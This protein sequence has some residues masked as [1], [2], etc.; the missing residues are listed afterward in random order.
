M[1]RPLVSV[2]VP[3]YN[4]QDYLERCLKSIVGQTYNQ[5]EIIL[6]DDG[7]SDACPAICDEWA[8]RDKRIKVIH[9]ANAGLGMA[10]N[11]GLELASGKYII[12]PDSDDYIDSTL[13]EKCVRAAEKGGLEVVIFGRNDV[14][15]N[16]TVASMPQEVKKQ[17]FSGDEIKNELIP[18]MFTYK[19]G[20]GVSAWSKLFS[21]ELFRR[22]NITFMSEREI[23]SEDAYFAVEL[24]SAVEKAGVLNERLYY[25]CKRGNSL[26]GLFRKDRQQKNDDFYSKTAQLIKDKKLPQDVLNA[27]AARYQIYTFSHLKQIAASD[28]TKKQMQK[29]IN[30]VFNSQILQF[31][32]K[33]NII[34][35]HSV[36]LKLFYSLLKMKCYKLCELMLFAKMKN[37]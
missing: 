30:N 36:K 31:T 24:F 33:C 29:E 4:V 37:N 17:Y 35:L 34:E 7:S 13:V 20:F 1:E 18:A 6:V 28:L 9:K 22:N 11:S 12:F 19:F 14:D 27:M 23:I 5:L 8:S 21:L 16:G 3:I 26:T 10:R 2:V 25:Y 32:L 15:E